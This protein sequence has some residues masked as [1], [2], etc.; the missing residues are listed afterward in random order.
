M[1]K[2]KK[3]A[4]KVAAA[5]AK[6]TTKAKPKAAVAKA[7]KTA[8]AKTTKS[9]AKKSKAARVPTKAVK[10]TVKPAVK[11]S[12]VSKKPTAKKA[13]V[14][15]AVAKKTSPVTKLAAKPTKK[16]DFAA[17]LSPLDDRVLVQSDDNSE[18][19]TASGLII[20]PQT[21]AVSGHFR[22]VVVAVGPGHKDKKGRRRSMDVR[23]G[24]KILFSEYAGTKIQLMGQDLQ[25]VRES[26]ILGIE[27]A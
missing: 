8:K 12:T 11:K 3:K 24:D 19:V 26:E 10:K 9:V 15:P 6:K 7:K 27:E 4:K 17:L 18:K 2:V 21:A 25:L 1:A 13:S 22:G 5:K 16:I 14:K 20:I 23:T